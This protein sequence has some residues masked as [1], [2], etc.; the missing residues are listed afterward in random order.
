LSAQSKSKQNKD[1]PRA[2]QMAAASPPPDNLRPVP[3]PWQKIFLAGTA[4]LLI[5]W[6][7]LLVV[8][9]WK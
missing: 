7:A 5:A 3:K 8:L 6:L 1:K 4:I 9:A 2:A